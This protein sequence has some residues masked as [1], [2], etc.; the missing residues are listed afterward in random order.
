MTTAKRVFLYLVSLVTLGIFAAG[1]GVLLSL[2]LGLLRA[3]A[4]P[5]LVGGGFDRAELSRGLAL[6]LIGGGLWAV[7]WRMVQQSVAADVA[8]VGTAMRKLYLNLVQ[9][10]AALTGLLALADSLSWL[11]GGAPG[12]SLP[13]GRLAAFMVAALVWYYHWRL[14]EREGQPTPAARTLRRWYVYILAGWGLAYLAGSLV[15]FIND[16][17]RYLPLWGEVL[18]TGPSWN[19]SAQS[20]LA[21]ILVGGL[22]WGFHWF[23]LARHDAGA[24]LR[25]VYLY[26][27]AI[28]A[29][30]IAALVALTTTIYQLLR[31]AFGVP[32]DPAYLMFL[33]WTI[34]AMLVGAAIWFYHERLAQEEAAASREQ[35]L[36][37]RRV[38]AYLLSFISL[39][40]LVAG[41]MALVGLLLTFIVDAASS[42]IVTSPGWWQVQLSLA[43][44]LLLVG[45]PLW[46][47]FWG[48]VLR[49][50]AGDARERRTR[51][52]RIFL[53]VVVGVGIIA[54][55]AAAVNILYQLINGLLQGLTLNTL[56]QMRWSLQILVVGVPFLVYFWRVLRGDQ[57]LGAEAV[58]QQKSVTLIA[59]EANLGLAPRLAARLGYPVRVLQYLGET[60]QSTEVSED[61][62]E[63]LAAEVAAAPAPRVLVLVDGAVRVLP[64]RER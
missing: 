62:L 45:T 38:Y 64:Y 53:Y 17:V 63:R 12:E 20:D 14:S 39:G 61:A 33:G 13:S 7:F 23:V 18:V 44:A 30:A 46:L 40:T 16:L 50:V 2:L 59:S 54:L 9:T 32:G 3:A 25:Q 41:L 24:T 51:S 5:P 56:Q 10:V 1:I 31:F 6:L 43:L 47:Y 49:M 4:S 42:A 21:G 26:L 29:S 36:S 52:R 57:R 37:A 19:A 55:A 8:E 35:H 11:F 22:A 27:F 58:A 34:P 28:P 15:A 48:Q 60:V